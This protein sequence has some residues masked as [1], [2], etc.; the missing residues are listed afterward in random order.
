MSV[1]P[2]VVKLA[3]QRA[4]GGE[5]RIQDGEMVGAWHRD[6]FSR[7]PALAQ[8]RMIV[9]RLTSQFRQLQC[10][11]I[12]RKRLAARR[13]AARRAE[14]F[15][16]PRGQ[17]QRPIDITLLQRRQLEQAADGKDGIHQRMLLP[18]RRQLPA[19]EWPHR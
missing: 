16:L 6:Q 5:Q 7:Q 8:R 2:V 17:L 13:R 15:N 9:L 19:A 4:V 18:E 3:K 14:R 12:Q 10:A 11:V 1:V